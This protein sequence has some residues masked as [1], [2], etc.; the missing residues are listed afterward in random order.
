LIHANNQEKARRRTGL[1]VDVL[2]MPDPPPSA[3]DGGPGREADGLVAILSNL[4]RE[5]SLPLG[6]LRAGIGQIIDAGPEVVSEA[7]R[8]Q[9]QTLLMV[10]DDLERLT[11]ECLGG[12]GSGPE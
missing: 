6:L 9:A 5:I 10:C 11:R 8:S 12:E 2:A 1:P 4:S 7:E 3:H